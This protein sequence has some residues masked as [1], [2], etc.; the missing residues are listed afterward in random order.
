LY[1][2]GGEKLDS[3]VE[4]WSL[5][6]KGNWKR[7]GWIKVAVLYVL[8]RRV[9]EHAADWS[10]IKKPSRPIYVQKPNKL[11]CRKAINCAN[12]TGK[13]FRKILKQEDRY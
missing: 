1:Q 5:E 7:A 3:L 9:L 8:E 2:G 11:T 10:G 13:I 12:Y 6:I 4:S